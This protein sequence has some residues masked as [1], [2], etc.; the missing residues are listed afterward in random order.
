MATHAYHSRNLTV[1]ARYLRLCWSHGC[2]LHAIHTQKI[3]N[4]AR[5]GDRIWVTVTL[6]LLLV[7]DVPRGAGLSVR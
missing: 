6:D 1:V 3:P 4:S 5:N 7:T 2:F